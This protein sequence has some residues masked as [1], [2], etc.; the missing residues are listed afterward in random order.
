V[1]LQI[2]SIS[3]LPRVQRNE[4]KAAQFALAGTRSYIERFEGPICFTGHSYSGIVAP[5]V[6]V[7]V[8]TDVSYKDMNSIVLLQ[9][10]QWT[11]RALV[12]TKIR[13]RLL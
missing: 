6:E 11:M 4:D 9:C 13:L 5:V 2:F 8:S 1:V 7:I 3:L 10:H 12:Y